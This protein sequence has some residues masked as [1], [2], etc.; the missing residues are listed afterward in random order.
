M[1]ARARGNRL[2]PPD[3]VPYRHAPPAGSRGEIFAE[4]VMPA[5]EREWIPIKDGVWT[6]P[7]CFNVTEGYWTHLLRVTRSGVINRHRHASPVHGVVLRGSWFYLEHDWVAVEGS[8]IFEPPGD[9]HTLYVPPE[10]GEM[11]TFFHT[12]GSLIYVDPDGKVEA[13]EDV[14]TRLELARAHYARV[15]LEPARLEAITR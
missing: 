15:G 11:I 3:L 12:T 9:S 10:V 7:L 1:N 14:F 13:Y 6:R 8:Y 2:A 5:D 4:A